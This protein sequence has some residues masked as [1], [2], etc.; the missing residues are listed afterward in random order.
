M[1][2]IKL[3]GL[4]GIFSLMIVFF[5]YPLEYSLLISFDSFFI[6]SSYVFVD[7]FFVLSGF[8]ISLNYANFSNSNDLWVYI[9]KRFI[10]LYPLLFFTSS[11]FLIFNLISNNFLPDLTNFHKANSLIINNYIEDILFTNSNQILGNSQGLNIPSW[12]ISAEFISYIVYGLVSLFFISKSKKIIIAG[13]IL[14]SLYYY[15]YELDFYMNNSEFGFLRSIICFHLGYFVFILSKRIKK[16]NVLFEYAIPVL[17]ILILYYINNL[18]GNPKKFIFGFIT[19]VFFSI[20]ILILLKTRGVI[21]KFLEFKFVQFLGK[22]SFSI[23]LTHQLLLVVITRIVFRGLNFEIT[24]INELVIFLLTLSIIVGW[25][26]ITYN[27]IEKKATL[28]LKKKILK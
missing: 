9:K 8:V 23:Y 6:R 24:L 16:I 27:M 21:S 10:R 26:S 22:V 18:E 28:F 11:I 3:D 2:I 17:L 13:I 25:S 20:S 4:R 14:I 5:H 12:S 19:P 15:F 1:R 7:F